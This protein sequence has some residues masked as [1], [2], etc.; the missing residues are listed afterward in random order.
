MSDILTSSDAG[1]M[2]ITLNRVEKKNAITSAMY[3]AMAD[4]LQSAADDTD[5]RVIVFQG[6]ETFFSARA[7]TSAIS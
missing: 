2:T 3:T 4:A 1:V 5:I 7:T 6:Q